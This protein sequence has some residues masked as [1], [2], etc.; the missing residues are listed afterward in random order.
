MRREVQCIKSGCCCPQIQKHACH[1]FHPA[2]NTI[3][4]VNEFGK[5]Y[6]FIW[7]F[8]LSYGTQV[9]RKVYVWVMFDVKTPSL[10]WSVARA[11]WKKQ[12]KK[13][14]GSAAKSHLWN[15]Q[16]KRIMPRAAGRPSVERDKGCIRPALSQS[17]KTEYYVRFFLKK[18]YR[19]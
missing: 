10:P 13:P 2:T 8:C 1:M 6:N 4:T 18:N 12:N 11:I 7:I 14:Q 9:W 15:R 17:L 19:L 5:M 16:S 3:L